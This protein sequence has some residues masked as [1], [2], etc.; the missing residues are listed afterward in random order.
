M[1][2]RSP[3]PWRLLLGLLLVVGAG[4]GIWL[5]VRTPEPAGDPAAPPLPYRSRQAFSSSGNIAVSEAMEPWPVSAS[6]EEVARN[7]ANAPARMRSQLDA[8]LNNPS[9]P[10]GGRIKA[11]IYLA[12]LHHF[13]GHAREAYAVLEEAR[14]L[15]EANPADAVNWLYTVVYYQGLTTLRRGETENC[16]MCRG[17]SSCIL[18]LAPAAVHTNPDGSRVAIRHFTEYLEKFPDD[19]Q[20]RWLMNLAHMTLGEHPAGVDPRFVIRLDSWTKSEFDLGKFRDVGAQVGINRFNEAGATILDDFD[21]DGL[22]DILFTTYNAALPVVLYR[23]QGTGKFADVTEKAKLKGQ[24]GELGAAQADFDNDGHLDFYLPRGA[25]QPNPIR[26]SLM[27]NN[28]DGTFA[29]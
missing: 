1:T 9:L 25:W 8:D 17:E 19:Y 22:Y 10:S 20:V 7:W 23:N 14:A 21:N 4:I 26:P 13:S 5:A 3:A 6:L 18:P 15:A 16:V 29:D 11:L 27:R 2:G 28:G 12:S 24:L